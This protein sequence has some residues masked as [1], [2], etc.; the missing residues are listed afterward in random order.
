[1]AGAADPCW[2]EAKL[3]P[4]VSHFSAQS[5]LV[6]ARNQGSVHAPTGT[7]SLPQP[8]QAHSM[9]ALFT[10]SSGVQHSPIPSPLKH[11]ISVCLSVWY[12]H[13]RVPAEDAGAKGGSL[14]LGAG[15]QAKH[16]GSAL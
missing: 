3:N 11:T 16:F 12:M 8:F 9:C 4:P 15:N 7:V 6:S 1:M 2:P 5:I 10:V 13:V 14:D